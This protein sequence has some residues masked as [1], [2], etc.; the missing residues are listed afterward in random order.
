MVC[1]ANILVVTTPTTYCSNC[2]NEALGR[3]CSN[4]GSPIQ[5]P[6]EALDAKS[7]EQEFF[8]AVSE[9]EQAAQEIDDIER[10]I[11]AEL[12]NIRRAIEGETR[13]GGLI[14]NPGDIARAGQKAFNRCGELI[15][16]TAP[17][18]FRIS[19][20]AGLAVQLEE[21]GVSSDDI[22]QATTRL[23]AFGSRALEFGR[24]TEALTNWMNDFTVAL[25]HANSPRPLR[26]MTP[27]LD[28]EG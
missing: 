5:E 11:I 15:P 23:R 17:S 12:R 21:R 27:P 20:A 1:G 4:C 24:T 6:L 8:R 3:F 13:W 9:A 25:A 18:M 2:G 7:L 19:A 28:W 16:K 14:F 26:I 10:Q 22:R